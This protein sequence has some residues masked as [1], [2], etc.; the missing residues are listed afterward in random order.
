[1]PVKALHE[2]LV[3]LAYCM[4]RGYDEDAAG[5]LCDLLEYCRRRI[6]PSDGSQFKD[7][8]AMVAH[9]GKNPA[10]ISSDPS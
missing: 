4:G 10:D 6:F 9:Y 2:T 3:D 7:L 5:H 8:P 1:M